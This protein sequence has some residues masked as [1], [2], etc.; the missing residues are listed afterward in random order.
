MPIPV[1]LAHQPPPSGGSVPTGQ[2]S[3]LG[4]KESLSQK[5]SKAES[6]FLGEGVA[7]IPA[8]LVPKISKGDFV[9]MAELLHNN[10]ELETIK[11]DSLASST[12]TSSKCK[13]RKL[14]EDMDGLLSWIECFSSF[15]ILVECASWFS[16]EPGSVSNHLQ[17]GGPEV[18]IPRLAA[19]R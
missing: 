7:V 18:Q 2:S 5:A 19:V 11:D 12:S 9:E 17:S 8:R 6:F 14:S 10:P 16:E 1:A 4:G 13:C 3:S 15:A